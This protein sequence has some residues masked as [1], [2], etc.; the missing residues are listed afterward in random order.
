MRD[1]SLPS[2]VHRSFIEYVVGKSDLVSCRSDP[3]FDEMSQNLIK[4]V[5]ILRKNVLIIKSPN[6]QIILL[7]IEPRKLNQN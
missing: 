5:P 4:N 1:S 2:N 6:F 3:E 7:R